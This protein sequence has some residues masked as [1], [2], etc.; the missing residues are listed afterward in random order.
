MGSCGLAASGVE[1]WAHAG[2]WIA[3]P[4]GLGQVIDSLCTGHEADTK[5][6]LAPRGRAAWTAS[7]EQASNGSFGFC[8]NLTK[9]DQTPTMAKALGWVM[10]GGEM[11]V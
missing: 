9:V 10:R 4:E 7:E 5:D 8:L 3:G 1:P 2:S 6:N 11:L